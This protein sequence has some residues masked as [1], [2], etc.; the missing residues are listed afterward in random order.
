[1]QR[2]AHQ[3]FDSSKPPITMATARRRVGVMARASRPNMPVASI[4][5]AAN[6]WPKTTAATT[7]TTPNIGTDQS[8]ATTYTVPNNPPTHIHQGKPEKSGMTSPYPRTVRLTNQH[9]N[10]ATKPTPKEMQAQSNGSSNALFRVALIGAWMEMAMPPAIMEA[11]ATPKTRAD[12]SWDIKGLSS[13][14]YD[15]AN[16]GLGN[17]ATRWATLSWAWLRWGSMPMSAMDRAFKTPL[18]TNRRNTPLCN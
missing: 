1:M 4:S 6:S 9:S 5:S 18:S 13:R 16:T 3:N 14:G 7:V 15:A 8:A 17:W 11:T 10:S 2:Q 12:G